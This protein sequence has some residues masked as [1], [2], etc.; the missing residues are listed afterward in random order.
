MRRKDKKVRVR[1]PRALRS[2]VRPWK[3][4]RRKEVLGALKKAKT[5]TE[6]GAVV[7][8]AALL[9][10]SNSMMHKSLRDYRAKP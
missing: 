7:L 4:T 10:G 2:K 8:A 1:T 5:D 9:G 3:K 6:I